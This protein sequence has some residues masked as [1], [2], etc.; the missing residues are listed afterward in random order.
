M[1]G[2]IRTLL[3][4]AA[5]FA[6]L[7][8]PGRQEL[9][10]Q[11]P[12]GVTPALPPIVSTGEPRFKVEGVGMQALDET[13]ADFWGN[14]EVVAV[15][16]TPNYLVFSSEHGGMSSSDGMEDFFYGQT[17]VAPATDNGTSGSP[18]IRRWDCDNAG[19]P[20]P[21]S[22]IV[23]LYEQDEWPFSGYCAQNDD[24]RLGDTDLWRP[25]AALCA[26]DEGTD[27]ELIGK[28]DIDLPLEEL[29]RRMPHAGDT[30]SFDVYLGGECDG[31]AT[32]QPCTIPYGGPEYVVTFLVTRI[33]DQPPILD[34]DP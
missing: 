32:T 7:L 13:G 11:S 12:G 20:A 16:I 21:V 6:S 34:P 33:A 30:Y 19:M 2:P 1:I 31:S 17:C 15:F 5:T 26:G 8:V 10:A 29:L 27:N 23:A 14:D 18:V 22:F 25:D 4:L 3:L 28:D 9:L 24:D